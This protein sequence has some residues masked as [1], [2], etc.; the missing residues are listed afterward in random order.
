MRRLGDQTGQT[1]A[2]YV[3]LL[4]IVATIIGAL[5]TTGLP[6]TIARAAQNAICDIAGAAC[7]DEEE[8]TNGAATVLATRGEQ[9]TLR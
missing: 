6:G 1:A 4:L 7:R 8:R 3:G 9:I 5:V 2:E